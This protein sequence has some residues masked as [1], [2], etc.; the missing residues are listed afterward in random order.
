[1][2]GF[3]VLHRLEIMSMYNVGVSKGTPGPKDVR[4]DDGL[5]PA[6]VI[7]FCSSKAEGDGKLTTSEPPAKHQNAVPGMLRLKI[8]NSSITRCQR[9]LFV[10]SFCLISRLYK[11]FI[12]YIE[13]KLH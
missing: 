12:F 10:D 7:R 11:G 4:V 9:P 2:C 1:M 8:A 5:L 6:A 3:M 13:Q